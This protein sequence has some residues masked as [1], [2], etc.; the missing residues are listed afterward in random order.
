MNAKM[1]SCVRCKDLVE[2][3]SSHTR[4][5]NDWHELVTMA[6]G[7]NSKEDMTMATE[8]A[9]VSIDHQECTM[10][11]WILTNLCEKCF[12]IL[13]LSSSCAHILIERALI[14]KYVHL[15]YRQCFKPFSFAW[16]AIRVQCTC[17]YL[18]IQA[19]GDCFRRSHTCLCP[20][21]LIILHPYCAHWPVDYA[22]QSRFIK[23]MH[24]SDNGVTT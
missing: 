1:M 8:E 7:C 12:Q 13:I 2:W 5:Q 22:F 21:P 14:R 11:T 9:F 16:W 4:A 3:H 20:T 18:Q 17:H 10:M 19:K 15:P 23:I 6:D 24:T